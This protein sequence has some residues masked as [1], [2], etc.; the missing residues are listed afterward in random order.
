MVSQWYWIINDIL[1]T[2]LNTS[3]FMPCVSG[4]FFAPLDTD[5]V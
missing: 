3:I 2:G 4:Q 1:N 5:V